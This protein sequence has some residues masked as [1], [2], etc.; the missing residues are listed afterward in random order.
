VQNELDAIGTS[1]LRQP[2]TLADLLRRPELDYESLEPLDSERRPL[3]EDVIF[4]VEVE[5]KYEGYIERQKAQ[6]ERFKRLE[7]RSIPDELDFDELEGMSLEGR[8]RLKEVAPES[9]GQA[10][11]ISG[12]SPAD[13]SVLLVHVEGNEHSKGE[14]RCEA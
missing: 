12:V 10:M 5:L 4:G 9:V 8:E 6:V 3:P 7:G 13:I 1:G 2:A 11:R 14:R